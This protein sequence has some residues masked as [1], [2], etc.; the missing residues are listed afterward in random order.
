MPA[1]AKKIVEGYNENKR[2]DEMLLEKWLL[3]QG[4]LNLFYSYLHSRF[5]DVVFSSIDC[6]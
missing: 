3:N 5:M 6:L 1:Y 2:V 4:T